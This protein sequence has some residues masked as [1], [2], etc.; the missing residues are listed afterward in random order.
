MS[1][2]GWKSSILAWN[3]AENSYTINGNSGGTESVSSHV[4]FLEI[5]VL[6]TLAKHLS[7]CCIPL[8]ETPDDIDHF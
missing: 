4:V 8:E 5:K 3:P 1:S 7:I 2:V 6:R